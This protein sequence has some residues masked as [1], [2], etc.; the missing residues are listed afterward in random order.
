MLPQLLA[1]FPGICQVAD[2]GNFFPADVAI[3]TDLHA[4]HPRP[5]EYVEAIYDTPNLWAKDLAIA[6]TFPVVAPEAADW[7]GR[8]LERDLQLLLLVFGL[9][10]LRTVFGP[11]LLARN[12][13]QWIDIIHEVA[14]AS[15]TIGFYDQGTLELEK[16]ISGTE[17][18]S[19][20]YGLRRGQPF[21][22]DAT[23]IHENCP[24]TS[25]PGAPVTLYTRNTMDVAETEDLLAENPEGVVTF[26]QLPPSSVA[27]HTTTPLSTKVWQ[28][29]QN[30]RRQCE[31][32]C[33]NVIALGLP[34]PLIDDRAAEDAALGVPYTI[35]ERDTGQTQWVRHGTGPFV[36]AHYSQDEATCVAPFRIMSAVWLTRWHAG[37]PLSKVLTNPNA[38]T[39]LPPQGESDLVAIGSARA[40]WR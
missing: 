16:P 14:V 22:I 18:N 11:K 4:A 33:I 39:L 7:V 30:K 1:Q 27:T 21:R 20:T 12:K 10:R 24:R 15:T 38:T 17:N 6:L 23:V 8:H 13:D 31:C 29:L 19:D 2:D 25:A 35:V 32:G 9:Q 34:R 26:A 5:R 37:Y 40:G 28:A 36:P 3:L